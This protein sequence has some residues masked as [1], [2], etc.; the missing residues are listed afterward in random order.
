M[1]QGAAAP[2]RLQG[3]EPPERHM[4][5]K[6]GQGGQ[7]VE[8]GEETWNLNGTEVASWREG[9]RTEKRKQPGAWRRRQ[10]PQSGHKPAIQ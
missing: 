9:I 8:R 7:G 1:S 4:W 3:S 2:I 6:D 10:G 5:R